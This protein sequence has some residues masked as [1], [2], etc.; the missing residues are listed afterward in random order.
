MLHA[1]LA[2]ATTAA[3]DKVF[4]CKS[5]NSQECDPLIVSKLQAANLISAH[6]AN[7]RG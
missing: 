3:P 4:T 2:C 1:I 5:E 6:R 7:L